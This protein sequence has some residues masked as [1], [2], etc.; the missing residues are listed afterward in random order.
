[1]KKTVLGAIA[2]MLPLLLVAS[3]AT[4]Q[5]ERSYVQELALKK[6][7]FAGEWYFAST[8]VD[9]PYECNWA[10]EGLQGDNYR[11]KWRIEKDY[12]YAY[13]T[14]EVVRGSDHEVERVGESNYEGE[15]VAAFKII[16]HFDIRRQYNSVN[17][18]EY[19]VI[20]ENT[21]DRL[22]YDREYMRVDWS[23][24]LITN[25]EFLNFDILYNEGDLVVQPAT[26]FVESPYDK[27]APKFIDDDDDGVLD[28]MDVV[29]RST[30]TNGLM[31]AAYL[32]WGEI[33]GT[34][35]ITMRH[36]FRRITDTDYEPRFHP[37][38]EFEH[39][40][41][42]RT[43]EEGLMNSGLTH[44]RQRG[45]TDFLDYY[46][47][48]HNIWQESHRDKACTRDADCKDMGGSRCDSYEKMCTIPYAER[49]PRPIIYY[50]NALFPWERYETETHYIENGWNRSFQ[51]TVN[52]LLFGNSQKIAC[53]EDGEE[54]PQG[55]C[56]RAERQ[57]EASLAWNSPQRTCVIDMFQI[58]QNDCNA[59][60]VKAY[61]DRHPKL[62]E[63]VERALSWFEGAVVD[64][65]LQI[66]HFDL[67]EVC[68]AV[69]AASRKKR[70]DPPFSWQQIGD[71]RY[72]MINYVNNP[73]AASPLGYGPAHA[74]IQT[75][76]IV[77]A[78]ANIYGGALDSYEGFI[79]D[80]L[81]LVDGTVSDDRF[82]NG[83]YL[84]EYFQN[85]GTRTGMPTVP[86]VWLPKD[87]G[88]DRDAV[89][90]AF[91]SIRART[92]DW[93]A[94]D[95]QRSFGNRITR[96]AG[97]YIE[98]MLI[99]DE[100]LL[101]NGIRPG[102]ALTESLMD[103]V[104]PTRKALQGLV[105]RKDRWERKLLL[106]NISP[107]NE[108]TDYAVL[109]LIDDA[110]R[111]ENVLHEE[112]KGAF[113]S[114]DERANVG[115]ACPVGNECLGQNV[116]SAGVCAL[117][118]AKQRALANVRANPQCRND[119]LEFVMRKVFRGVTEHELGHTLG[120]RHNFEGSFDAEGYAD[121][122]WEIQRQF[123]L[124]DPDG[125][126]SGDG[127][128]YDRV[129]QDEDGNWVEGG[130]GYLNDEE[131][132]RY[133]QDYIAAKHRQELA[134]RDKYMLSSIMDYGGQF[135]SDFSGICKYDHAAIKFGYGNLREIYD[136]RDVNYPGT[137]EPKKPGIR[138]RLNTT[139]YLGGEICTKNEDCPQFDA[140]VYK[141][142]N[143]NPN[144]MN[145]GPAT[146][147]QTCG[148]KV[149]TRENSR[150]WTTM[151]WLSAE[152]AAQFGRGFCSNWDEDMIAAGVTF[153]RH[154]MCADERTGDR[155]FCSTW[156]EGASS[157]E[158]VENMIEMYDRLYPINNFRRYRRNFYDSS[159]VSRIFGRY[160]TVIGKQHQA[161]F[162]RLF[163]QLGFEADSGPG[164]FA[165]MLTASIMG[166]NFFGR[167]LTTPAVGP[168]KR[169][170][171]TGVLQVCG[172][173]DEEGS[174]SYWSGNPPSDFDSTLAN[175]GKYQWTVYETGYYGAINRIA[176]FG[177]FYDKILALE[178]LSTR[179][180]AAV[181]GND[182][183]IPLNY[184]DAYG[185]SMLDLFSGIITGRFNKYAPIAVFNDEGTRVDHLM[186]RDFWD[187]NF[188]GTR[189]TR[190]GKKQ[191][192]L[193]GM[194]VDHDPAKLA[195]QVETD[196]RLSFLDPDLSVIHQIYGL[197]YSLSNFGA[198]F[199][200]TFTDYV[201]LQRYDATWDP[202]EDEDP[203][204]PVIEYRSPLRGRIYRAAQ[205]FDGKSI[206]ADLLQQANEAKELYELA[207]TEDERQR[208][209]QRLDSIESFLNIAADL[210][211]TLGA[212]W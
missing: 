101:A 94:L 10:F 174:C 85:A 51:M 132:Y 75:G 35:Q 161:M 15:P 91:A 118:D 25:I 113:V 120:L 206:A 40:A 117:S 199:D 33:L 28:Y 148:V 8:V 102:T 208:A 17:G 211:V 89:S 193:P 87:F 143:Y 131:Y 123:P 103:A 1:M 173:S 155:P 156:D 135:Y 84:R 158:I 47:V 139:Y 182:E 64:G 36:S 205:T 130:D 198:F 142:E 191:S 170:P 157:T 4:E 22:W 149:T 53:I 180:W 55:C 70:I 116:C 60:N 138:R 37:D 128:P 56:T 111:D 212:S 163:Y 172:R 7:A 54:G 204:N 169:N 185:T 183:S 21:R 24:N 140:S 184:Y 114:P 125:N 115:V 83:E 207:Q 171:T 13:R 11:I 18:E 3:C 151:E 66:G 137:D 74:D 30:V 154:R 112:C 50:T 58:R 176:Q 38:D 202:T 187:G 9:V 78:C 49:T 192:L 61:L 145:L 19:N 164:G 97:T 126:Y 44:D 127:L 107:V 80:V 141:R 109:N 134:G 29:T 189:L 203:V 165:D 81:D 99:N 100:L 5:E 73:N 162:W 201:Q 45:E 34:S 186:Q 82:I 90:A 177:T 63:E 76:E 160:F 196:P 146:V 195:E 197:I 129:H 188:F 41:Y 59:A 65:K 69:E 62:V 209:R 168:Y 27:W 200:A 2:L 96:L 110:R 79:L 68:G 67:P 144:N 178:A 190:E 124:P 92:P 121:Q 133:W 57:A 98:D 105:E 147:T 86:Q 210:V 39:F 72:N 14:H 152:Q 88:L 175:G 26:F 77:N 122:Y 48:R 159:Y 31:Q 136:A 71:L 179:Q 6:S 52:E 42:F 166:M 46:M 108:Y 119:I 106:R 194:W 20:E 23:Q 150:I 153:P 181:G 167:V 95:R 104:S 93:E 32:E 43:T 16:S 12:L